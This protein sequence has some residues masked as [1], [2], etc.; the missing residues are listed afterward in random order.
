MT[1][2]FTIAACAALLVAALGSFAA[3]AS[4]DTAVDTVSGDTAKAGEAETLTVKST[5]KKSALK[6][7]WDT[8]MGSRVAKR[9]CYRSADVEQA[10]ESTRAA[11]A[12]MQE[13]TTD[14]QNYSGN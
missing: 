8:P 13:A 14:Y 11:A 5:S 7:K 6:C 3:V 1:R 4:A 10:Q 2:S 9:I 12:T